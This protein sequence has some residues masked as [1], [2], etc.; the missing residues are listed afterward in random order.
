[1]NLEESQSFRLGQMKCMTTVDSLW[2]RVTVSHFFITQQAFCVHFDHFLSFAT[3]FGASGSHNLL[4]FL[5]NLQSNLVKC[6]KVVNH[7]YLEQFVEQWFYICAPWGHNLWPRSFRRGRRRQET[8]WLKS[9]I[10]QHDN[11]TKTEPF[12]KYEKLHSFVKWIRFWGAIVIKKV[13][14]WIWT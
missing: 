7:Y 10:F 11:W 2:W 8:R 4:H 1:M 13:Q 6:V 14:W 5:L 3:F 9:Q 12:Y